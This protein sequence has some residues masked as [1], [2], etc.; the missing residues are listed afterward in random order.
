[1]WN[2]YIVEA[3]EVAFL[4]FANELFTRRYHRVMCVM[5]IVVICAL[6]PVHSLSGVPHSRVGSTCLAV[7]T[8]L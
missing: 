4:A 6:P 3:P 5:Y 2:L 8:R 7:D 1:M